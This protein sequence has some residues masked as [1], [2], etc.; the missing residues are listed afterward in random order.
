MVILKAIG[1]CEFA[2]CSSKFCKT[3]G[4]RFKAM[5]E[6]RKLRSQ[7]TNSGMI[8]RVYSIILCV[9]LC[10]E[11]ICVRKCVHTS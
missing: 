2:G 9:C 10:G 1:G 3:H 4:L 7:L 11:S 8:T 6:I 5:K